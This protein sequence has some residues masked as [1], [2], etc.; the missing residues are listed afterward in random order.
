MTSVTLLAWTVVKTKVAGEGGVDGDLSG[1]LV[2]NFADHDFVGV[3]AQDGT[4]PAREGKS[5]FFV[6]GNLGDAAHLIFDGIFDGDDLVFVVFDFVDGGV[7][8]G[9]LAGTCGACNQDHAVGLVDVT[10]EA[11]DVLRIEADYIEI[12]VAEFFAERFFIE[13]AEDGVFTVNRRHDGDAEVDEAAFVANAEAAILGDAALGDV[14]FAHYFNSGKDGGVPFLGEGL[15]GVLQDAVDA[16]LDDD[17]GVAGFD[18]DVT[19]AALEGRENHGVDE[20]DDGA[21][22]GVA[23][24]FVHGDVFV[25][26]FFVADDLERETFGGLVEDA[27]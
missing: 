18:V 16:V 1:F 19:G 15:H 3:V 4:Q 5:L 22:A 10:A 17:F 23:R 8:G 9:R 2:A 24:Q 7:E 14:E 6:Y 11:R 27:L 13:N 12:Q 21:D 26:V 25:A 20:T